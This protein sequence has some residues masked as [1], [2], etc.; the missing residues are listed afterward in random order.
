MIN[1]SPTTKS[2]QNS[3]DDNN[4]PENK[5]PMRREQ[6]SEDSKY[7]PE[8]AISLT[9]EKFRDCFES[10]GVLIQTEVK[11]KELHDSLGKDTK[12]FTIKLR[13]NSE[14][15]DSPCKETETSAAIHAGIEKTE[16]E[17]SPFKETEKL[18]DQKL[19][20]DTNSLSPKNSNIQIG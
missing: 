10:G 14:G 5:S 9:T 2:E 3:E 17:N 6:N 11:S 13:E 1:I 19:D 4:S 20:N 7:S 18:T 16:R 12:E 8:N 15:K